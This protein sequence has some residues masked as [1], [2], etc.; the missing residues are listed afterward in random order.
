VRS[1]CCV[2]ELLTAGTVEPEE[3]AVRR[4]MNVHVISDM[5]PESRNSSGKRHGEGRC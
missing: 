1:P 5:T 3:T 4:H 2:P